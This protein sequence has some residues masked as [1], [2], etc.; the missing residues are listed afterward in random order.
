M[1]QMTTGQIRTCVGC[2]KDCAFIHG[3]PMLTTAVYQHPGLEEFNETKLRTAT[4]T[5]YVLAVLVLIDF[6]FYLTLR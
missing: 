6:L 5:F 4:G 3:V 1:E 2:G